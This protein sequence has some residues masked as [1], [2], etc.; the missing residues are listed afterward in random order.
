M[1]N[2]VKR[3][4]L[5]RP[6]HSTSL[7]ETLLPKWLALPIFC[8][9]PLSSRGLRDRADPARARHRRRGP[10][11]LDPLGGLAVAALL[12]LVVWSYR[13]T[14]Y[15]YPNGGGA[16]AVSQRE[17]RSDGGPGRGQRADG[18]L[19]DDGGSVGHGRRGQHR[20]A[21]SRHCTTTLVPVSLV[22]I[23]LLAV[24]NLR[25]VKEAGTR[26]RHPDLRIHR[27][28]RPAARGRGRQDRD[29][30]HPVRAE[31]AD[32]VV[33]TTRR[34]GRRDDPAACCAPSLLV[35]R[36]F[37]GVEAISNGVP[38]FRRPKSHNAALTLL[39][40]GAIAV[41]MFVGRH[42]AGHHLRCEDRR[43][44]TGTRPPRRGHRSRRSSPSWAWRCSAAAASASTC[45]RPSPPR[46]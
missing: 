10:A 3:T 35:A 31:S 13:Q 28:R 24:M 29:W 26:V 30:R 17:P 4:L 36:R 7:G 39:L 22:F 15:A 27:L 45:C 25:G 37:T 38:F 9:D 42:L 18:R 16:Y 5:G 43:G 12:A 34:R 40:M 14:V 11:G 8:S 23:V 20:L 6:M 32:L 46:S 1:A 19:R 33:Q 44:S 21:P 41:A 2:A